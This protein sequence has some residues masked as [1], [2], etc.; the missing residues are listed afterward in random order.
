MMEFLGFKDRSNFRK[1][2][3]AS[4][5]QEEVLRLLYPD[6]PNHPRQKYLLTEKGLTIYN[7]ISNHTK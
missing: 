6:K 4:A 7:E 2:Y 3:L 1:N 5:I